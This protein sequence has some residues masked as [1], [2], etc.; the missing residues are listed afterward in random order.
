M[1]G[2]LKKTEKIQEELRQSVA[3]DVERII[4]EP[5][6]SVN[7]SNASLADRLAEL[8]EQIRQ[9]QRQERRRQAAIESLLETQGKILETQEQIEGQIKTPPPMEPI[10]A[11]A[12]NLALACLARPE[13]PASSILYNKLTDFL[14]YYGLSL[15]T[16]VGGPFDPERHE[17][18]AA[19]RDTDRPEDT[20]LEVVRPGFLSKGKVLRYATVIVNRYDAEPEPEEEDGEDQ[21]QSAE[22]YARCAAPLLRRNESA[23]WE[24]KLYD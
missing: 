15:V 3:S 20:V 10:M 16:D 4:A 17:A 19:R 13:D 9:G 12:D 21:G 7:S 24:A 2:L 11:L 8:E 23:S 18:C 22:P 14:A 1:F 6:A 5:L